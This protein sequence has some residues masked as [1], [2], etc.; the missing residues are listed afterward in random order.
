MGRAYYYH[1]K[2]YTISASRNRS[3]RQLTAI[4]SNLPVYITLPST[5]TTYIIIARKGGKRSAYMD[6]RTA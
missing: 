6:F 3:L 1:L 5:I 2:L 4:Y